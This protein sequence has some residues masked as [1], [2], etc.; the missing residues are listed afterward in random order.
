MKQKL[1]YMHDNPVGGNWNLAG[2]AAGYKHSSARFYISNI[3]A[4]YAVMNFTE[5][6]DVDLTQ[7]LLNNAEST[8]N[9]PGNK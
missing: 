3:H 5:L 8:A 7:P 6:D 1:G 4:G 9:A 2:T